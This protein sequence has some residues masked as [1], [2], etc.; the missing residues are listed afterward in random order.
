[1]LL[2]TTERLGGERE[3]CNTDKI[4][5]IAEAERL[6][7]QASDAAYKRQL[8]KEAIM[9]KQ[10]ENARRLAEM[11]TSDARSDA[12]QAQ[13]TIQRLIR[14]AE[15]TTNAPLPKVCLVTDWDSDGL[16]AIRMQSTAGDRETNHSGGSRPGSVAANP[17]RLTDPE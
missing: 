12:D 9:R 17:G 6:A 10:A 11:R 16:D 4:K 8:D 2:N 1:M 15:E 14:E 3:Q 7:R 13:T 5:A